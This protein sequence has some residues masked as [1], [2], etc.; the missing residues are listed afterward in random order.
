MTSSVAETVPA[1]AA[2]SAAV[3][4]V[5]LASVL[6]FYAPPLV[7]GDVILPPYVTHGL[8]GLV[9]LLA[10][11]RTVTLTGRPGRPVHL[12]AGFLCISLV[13]LHLLS[14]LAT[15]FTI[16]E[17]VGPDG[18]RV[19][20]RESAFFMSGDGSVGVAGRRGGPVRMRGV[21]SVDDVGTP[22]RDGHYRLIWGSDGSAVLQVAGAYDADPVEPELSCG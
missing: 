6:G 12:G 2:P 5:V 3:G 7:I 1:W 13:G 20:V 18:C 11:A 4:V 16:L 21:Y 9:A 10:L 22:I 19:V 14:S 8:A 15:T 17:P